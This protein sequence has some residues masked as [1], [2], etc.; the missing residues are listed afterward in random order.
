LVKTEYYRPIDARRD[1]F[2]SE[3]V[4]VSARP[5]VARSWKCSHERANK[6]IKAGTAATAASVEQP[7]TGVQ[8]LHNQEAG[9]S[10][11][12]LAAG[13]EGMPI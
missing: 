6:P 10:L 1:S 7:T 3:T 9:P 5:E 2:S 12:M 8:Q 11:G 13:A 4:P